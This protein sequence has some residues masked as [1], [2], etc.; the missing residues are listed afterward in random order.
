M[1][2]VVKW[3]TEEEEIRIFEAGHDLAI[4]VLMALSHIL[5]LPL[6]PDIAFWTSSQ[7]SDAQEEEAIWH[8]L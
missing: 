1:E 2:V 3:M 5:Q 6:F 8:T 7:L 4:K